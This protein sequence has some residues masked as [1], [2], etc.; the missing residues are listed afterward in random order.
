MVLFIICVTENGGK[1]IILL[2]ARR[3]RGLKETFPIYL[4]RKNPLSL[5]VFS[6]HPTRDYKINLHL[7]H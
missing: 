1:K 7:T 4:Q 3:T 2:T 6:D 5:Y